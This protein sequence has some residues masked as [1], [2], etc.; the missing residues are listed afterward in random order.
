MNNP[1]PI[2]VQ[3]SSVTFYS[4]GSLYPE[5]TPRYIEKWDVDEAVEMSKTMRDHH[6]ATPYGFQFSTR[7]RTE[8]EMDSH[9]LATSSFYYLGGTVETLDQI[10]E[11]NDPDD[12]ILIKNMVTNQWDRI[13]RCNT[14][15]RYVLPLMK[16]D[17]VLDMNKEK[18][19]RES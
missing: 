6:D 10:K 7:G 9:T 18:G 14:N 3:Q 17:I 11:R 19:T 13:I 5:E 8:D 12:S 4:P 2:Q 1:K 15:Y 16:E